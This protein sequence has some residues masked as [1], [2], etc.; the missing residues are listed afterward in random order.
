MDATDKYPI[1][2]KIQ[3]THP[4]HNQKHKLINNTIQRR[5]IKTSS[6]STQLQS[7]DPPSPDVPSQHIHDHKTQFPVLVLNPLSF[8]PCQSS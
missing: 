1:Q 4:T 5:P 7:D 6:R 3:L 8:P 2:E